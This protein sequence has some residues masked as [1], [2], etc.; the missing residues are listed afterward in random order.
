MFSYT[1]ITHINIKSPSMLL[2]KPLNTQATQAKSSTT[3]NTFKTLFLHSIISSQI[4]FN[5][6]HI[7]G[8]QENL[9]TL[10]PP[11]SYILQF[12]TPSML[13]NKP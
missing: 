4:F 1:Q 11:K 12:E 9:S 5:L 13:S 7:Q 10:K 2:N 6:Q 8:P 3:Q